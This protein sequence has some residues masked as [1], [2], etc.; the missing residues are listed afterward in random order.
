VLQP[1][2]DLILGLPVPVSFLA[3]RF[4]VRKSL[5]RRPKRSIFVIP[6][7]TAGSHLEVHNK[8]NGN[9]VRFDPIVKVFLLR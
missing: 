2:D 9:E 1:Q 3:G 6:L 5:Q 4:S 8:N 7:T